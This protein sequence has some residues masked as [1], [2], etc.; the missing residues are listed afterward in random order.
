MHD[1]VP[2]VRVRPKSIAHPRQH[3][4]LRS[5]SHPVL[6]ARPSLL[7]VRLAAVPVSGVEHRDDTRTGHSQHTL[8]NQS[9]VWFPAGLAGLCKHIEILNKGA[10]PQ[11]ASVCHTEYFRRLRDKFSWT[12]TQLATACQ[13]HGACT[14][15]RGPRNAGRR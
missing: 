2:E 14:V 10:N 7:S 9:V 13:Q 12:T 8:T 11:T 15:H 5:V 3:S 6:L 4:M 1:A